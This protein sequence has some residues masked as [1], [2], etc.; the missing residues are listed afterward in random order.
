MLLECANALGCQVRTRGNGKRQVA[1]AFGEHQILG[2]EALDDVSARCR[3]MAAVFA[4]RGN[5]VESANVGAI[6]IDV[7][8]DAIESEGRE[9]N[10]AIDDLEKAAAVEEEQRLGD[11]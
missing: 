4:M 2:S 10:S 5:L 3:A 9:A 7:A 11:V 8:L 1:V 6:E